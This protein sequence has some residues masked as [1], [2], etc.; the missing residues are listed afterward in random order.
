MGW[1]L[2]FYLQIKGISTKP[3]HKA[4]KFKPSLQEPADLSSDRTAAVRMFGISQ[5]V[6]LSFWV[7]VYENCKSGIGVEDFVNRTPKCR[8]PGRHFVIIS[9][10]LVASQL[11]NVSEVQTIGLALFQVM[12][13]TKN[14]TR[15]SEAS[16]LIRK[17][18]S[19]YVG[20]FKRRVNCWQCKLAGKPNW[21]IFE[22]KV[23]TT[24]M[25]FTLWRV[26]SCFACKRMREIQ[27]FI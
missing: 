11:T 3:K 12:L 20:H 14:D 15:N 8:H 9:H 22:I 17:T 16:A 27:P 23:E 7:F 10:P 1:P 19:W 18:F 25:M 26:I 6:Y 4:S 2:A 21:E 13:R 24:K 5:T